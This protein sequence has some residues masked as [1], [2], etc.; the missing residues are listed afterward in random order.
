M[1]VE[2]CVGDFCDY[3]MLE[4][5]RGSLT[6][7]KNILDDYKKQFGD[8]QEQTSNVA[9]S[10]PHEISNQL[11]LRTREQSADVIQILYKNKIF[12]KGSVRA[13]PV[14]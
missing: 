2:K 4:K 9:T 1:I 8:K 10:L 6:L 3:T 13:V 11:I 12:K 7:R 5:N 14:R